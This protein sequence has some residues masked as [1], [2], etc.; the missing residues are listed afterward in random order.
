[1]KPAKGT[2]LPDVNVVF[3]LLWPRHVHHGAASEWFRERGCGGWA[4]NAITQLG[5]M[6]L[7][8]NPLIARNAVTPAAAL[9]AVREAT[10]HPGHVFWNLDRPMADVIGGA[11]ARL[12]GHRQWNDLLLLRQAADRQGVLV[13]FDAGLTALLDAASRPHLLVLKP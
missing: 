6:R 1:M 5:V 3:A 9:E 8:T 13:T 4:T 10:A 2:F 12:T 7:L 11:A